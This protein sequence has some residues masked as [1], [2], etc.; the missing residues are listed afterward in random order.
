[1]LA[2]EGD[3]HRCNGTISIAGIVAALPTEDPGNAGGRLSA[4]PAEPRSLAF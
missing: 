3:L 2:D 1:M 4:A